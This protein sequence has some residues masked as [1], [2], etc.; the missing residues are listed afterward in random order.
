M[1][2]MARKLGRMP[3]K[4]LPFSIT[5]RITSTMCATGLKRVITW[6]QPGMLSTGVKRPPN[7]MKI[8]TKKNITNM[9]CCWLAQ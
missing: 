9:A 7:R 6:A 8:I 3:M 5:K 4:P 1:A 2:A